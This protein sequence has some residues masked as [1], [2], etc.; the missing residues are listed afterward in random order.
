MCVV[1]RPK[2][3]SMAKLDSLVEEIKQQGGSAHACMVV[4]TQL[5]ALSIRSCWHGT[6]A[7]ATWVG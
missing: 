6:K 1:R 3:E 4:P 2:P 7:I 5:L